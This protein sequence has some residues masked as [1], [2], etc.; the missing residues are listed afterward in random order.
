MRRVN[1]ALLT[2]VLLI[3]GLA[4]GAS[5]A[6]EG[7]P[8]PA[9]PVTAAPAWPPPPDGDTFDVT[10]FG[11]AHYNEGQGSVTM[12]I[13]VQ[14]TIAHA[15]EIVTFSSDMADIGTYDRMECFR[16]IMAPLLDAEIPWYDSP[17]NHDRI[18]IAGPG[19]VINGEIGPWRDVFAAMPEPWGDAPS[20]H[21]GVVVPVGAPDDGPGA[22]THYHLDFGPPGEPV[23]RL[24]VLD[25][26]MHS[27]TQ[28]DT[29]QYP[30][31]AP[32]GQLRYFAEK[33]AEAK[34]RGLLVFTMF[35]EPT[36]DPRDQTSAYPIS[37]NHTMNKGA[38]TDNL[39][40]DTIAAGLGVDGV[41]L[42]HIL[43][44]FVYNVGPV[45][46]FVDGGAGGTPYTIEPTGVDVGYH[47]AFRI[48]RFHRDGD[49][50]AFR[51]YVVPL[52]DNIE[53]T[54]PSGPVDAGETVELEAT[55][56]QPHDPSLPPRFSLMPNE[57]IRVELR[58]VQRSQL[59]A[60]EAVPEVAYM[61]STD[62][63]AVLAPVPGPLDPLDDPA[64]DPSTMTTSGRFE[65]IGTGDAQITIATGTHSAVTS[66]SVG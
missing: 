12:P 30:S 57:P 4:P 26:S 39:V 7:C 49:R 55:V 3:T 45:R 52:V 42:G 33:A 54:G 5:T 24:I 41:L 21:P 14:E 22:R 38:T 8:G 51:T 44:N 40:F 66:V 29:D 31:V 18:A 2:V 58:P 11:E 9:E 17:G 62:D 6:T 25:N 28:S 27:F 56:V 53:V 13:L 35:H 48:L 10:H 19:G 64:F 46:Y 23:F 63:P 50:W 65:A 37:Y 47:Y 61:W 15:P 16:D 32:G 43:G 36:Q 60:R 34:D 1:L 59:D 20:I